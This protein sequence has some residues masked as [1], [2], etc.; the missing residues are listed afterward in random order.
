M[1]K[2]PRWYGKTSLI[3]HLFELNNYNKIYIDVKRAAS[4]QMLS[5][6]IINEIYKYAGVENIISKAKESIVLLF[7]SLRA[8]LSIDISI[9]ELTIETLEKN[10]KKVID[11]SE[12]FLYAMDLVDQIS[13]KKKLDLKFAFDEF[14]DILLIA[15]EKILDKLRS[16]LQH[17][18]NTTY[19]FLGSIESIMNRIF[20]SKSSP[21]FHFARS[22]ELDGLDSGEVKE[23]CEEFFNKEG[24]SYDGFLFKTIDYLAGH[25]YYTMKT[26]QSIYYGSLEKN[27]ANIEKQ[28]CIDA[29]TTAFFETKSYL[30]EVI[31]KIKQKKY[32]H[33]VIWHLANG[34]KDEGIDSS[35]LYKT[36]KSLEDMGYI[37]RLDRG[38]YQ[39]TDIFL[40]I[41]LQQKSDQKLIEKEIE[42][43]DL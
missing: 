24:I 40:K 18:Q 36:Y 27:R 15:D 13:K 17:H 21:F 31:E 41:L 26:L 34:S 3:V 10:E 39:I 5:E 42:F 1:I 30:D 2:A 8:S 25:P 12:L 22:I 23:F 35:T 37:K 29:L 20:S 11:E 43:V 7:K 38:E 19:I 33:S 9:A 28:D 14:Q 32:H 6:Q 4:L 16:V